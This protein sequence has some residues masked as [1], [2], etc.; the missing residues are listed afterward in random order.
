MGNKPLRDH[1]DRPQNA[2]REGRNEEKDMRITTAK[3]IIDA[4]NDPNVQLSG[5]SAAMLKG[6]AEA[7][8]EEAFSAEMA[9]GAELVRRLRAVRDVASRLASIT[10]DDTELAGAA[11]AGLAAISAFNSDERMLWLLASSIMTDEQL[12]FVRNAFK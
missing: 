1:L 11:K 12:S 7:L 9:S 3:G 4:A 8:E 2:A 10:T 5:V 6:A